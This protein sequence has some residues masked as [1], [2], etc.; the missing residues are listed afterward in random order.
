VCGAKLAF[1]KCARMQKTII[2]FHLDA[3]ILN[4]LSELRATDDLQRKFD[5]FA[6][7]F[8]HKFLSLI[9][10]TYTETHLFFAK[11]N[12]SSLLFRNYISQTFYHIS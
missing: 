3:C 12:L 8:H 9:C 2:F 1:A 7:Y 5:T 11:N 6:I 10:S 4:L